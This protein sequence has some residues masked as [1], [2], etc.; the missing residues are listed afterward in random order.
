LAFWHRY[1]FYNQLAPG[2]QAFGFIEVSTDPFFAN[3]YLLQSFE[4][5][6]NTDVNQNVW[7]EE[8]VDLSQYIN[9]RVWLR[10]NMCQIFGAEHGEA[11]WYIDQLR[12]SSEQIAIPYFEQTLPLIVKH[13]FASPE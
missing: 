10:L 13:T 5:P 3:T 7:R 2:T 12:I 9:Q 4:P 8:V 6:D 11:F 1:H